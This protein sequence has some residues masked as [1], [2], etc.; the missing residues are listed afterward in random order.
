ME[1]YEIKEYPNYKVTKSGKVWSDISNRFLDGKLNKGYRVVCI[2]GKTVSVHRL[3]CMVFYPNH[4]NYGKDVNHK[5]GIRD[6]NR[7]ENLEWVTRSENQIHAYRQLGR[8]RNKAL[9]GR[10]GALHH[11]SKQVSVTIGMCKMTFGSANEASRELGIALTGI[12]A[13]ANGRKKHFHGLVFEY[14]NLS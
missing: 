12:C 11:T 8:K 10:L 3:V 2:K 6:D 14:T 7:V 5:N 4:K 1:L 9:K 13:S